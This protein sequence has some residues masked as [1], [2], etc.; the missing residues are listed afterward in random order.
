M[1][2]GQPQGLEAVI[3]AG[4]DS[5]LPTTPKD[6]TQPL[7]FVVPEGSHIELPD[8]SAWLDAP[9]RMTGIYRPATVESLSAV[10]PVG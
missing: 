4:R 9:S 5:A 7:I 3:Q 8:L 6:P 2:D 10:M 1:S